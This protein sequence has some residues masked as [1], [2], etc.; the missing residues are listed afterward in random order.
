MYNIIYN[1]IIAVFSL[2]LD[3]PSYEAVPGL[4]LEDTSQTLKQHQTGCTERA[5]ST[6][7]GL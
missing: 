6:S 1:N 5:T 3:R 7:S 2:Y 4:S